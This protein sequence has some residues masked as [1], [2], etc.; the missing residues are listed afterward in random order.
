MAVVK[1]PREWGYGLAGLAPDS[2]KAGINEVTDA[3]INELK[4]LREL[5][6]DGIAT[7]VLSAEVTALNLASVANG[8]QSATQTT[9]VTGALVGDIA[10][11]VGSAATVDGGDATKIG[12]L[13][14]Q[15]TAADTVKWFLVNTSGAAVDV[16]SMNYTVY[17]IPAARLAAAV[18]AVATQYVDIE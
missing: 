14:A 12:H 15:V 16:G 10:F 13:V 18:A 2:G 4:G 8:A 11:V 9:T 5:L 3:I 7:G 6:A 17:V 1:K